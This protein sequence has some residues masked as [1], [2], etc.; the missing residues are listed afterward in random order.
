[1]YPKLHRILFLDD[2]VVVQKDL[3]PLWKINMDGKV[4]G[5]VETCFGSFHRYGQ[6]EKCTEEYHYWQN[7][8]EDRTLWKS[9]TLPAGLIAF[10]STTKFLDKSWHVLGLGYN[11]SVSMDHIIMPLLSISMET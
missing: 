4:N 5:A 7:L 2:D 8:N 11:P 6:R 1:M 3:T 10:Y 9:G